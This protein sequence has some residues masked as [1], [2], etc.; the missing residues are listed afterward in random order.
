MASSQRA[1]P[2]CLSSSW[3]AWPGLAPPPLGP[4]HLGHA[5]F[6][7]IGPAP[8]LEE[9]GVAV[10]QLLAGR[11]Q[12]PG[13]GAERGGD[14]LAATQLHLGGTGAYW[15]ALGGAG[16]SWEAVGG[17]GRCWE[18]VGLSHWGALGGAGPY[19]KA[20]GGTRR[21]WEALELTGKH[22]E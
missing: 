6:S 7:Q 4:S 21:H 17:T 16:G 2:G 19:W 10:Q 18:A 1:S 15:E 3:G 14:A 11:E 5:P 20:L 12:L 8:Y 13:A 22:W 9:A